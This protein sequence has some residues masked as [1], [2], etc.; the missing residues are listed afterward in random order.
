MTA[1]G[2]SAEARAFQNSAIFRAMD[3]AR[4]PLVITDPARDDNPIVYANAAFLDLTGYGRDEVLGRNCR[5]L[6]GADTTAESRAALR[7]LI[8]SARV[9]TIEIVNY[10]K[11]G[12]RFINALQVGPIMGEDGKPLYFFGSQLDVSERRA[13]EETARRLAERELLHRFRNIVNVMS[14][15]IR[16]TARSGQ[17]PAEFSQT[18]IERL[19][20]LSEAHFDAIEGRGRDETA[21]RALVEPVL[22]AYAPMGRRQYRLTGAD[23]DIPNPL[24][25]PVTLAVHELAT[26]A[27]KHGALSVPEG[28]VDLS[29][30]ADAEGAGL[31]LRWEETGGPAVARP[32]RENGTGIVSDLVRASGGNMD[33]DWRPEGLVVVIRFDG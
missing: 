12:T 29:W 22:D 25:S 17:E 3:H 31:S 8:A 9:D 15:I 13:T 26:N 1:D 4:L 28:R 20:T 23:V 5:F 30:Q 10:R 32:G 19:T 16:M 7:D 18:L 2:S 21:L 11:D 24:I 27:V 6:Q 14:V 33:F